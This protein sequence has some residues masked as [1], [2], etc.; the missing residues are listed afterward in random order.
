MFYGISEGSNTCMST[1]NIDSFT[2]I[3]LYKKPEKSGG[4]ENHAKEMFDRQSIT[5]YC[6]IIQNQ[7]HLSSKALGCQ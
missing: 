4:F 5:R 7:R 6:N 3:R 1:Y 2:K